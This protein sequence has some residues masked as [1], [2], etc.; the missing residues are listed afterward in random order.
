[1]AVRLSIRACFNERFLSSAAAAMLESKGS[2]FAHANILAGKISRKTRPLT[3]HGQ[4]RVMRLQA[5]N[6][7]DSIASNGTKAGGKIV[8]N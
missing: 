2:S 7:R 8:E 1:M 5:G 3:N 6:V 4:E